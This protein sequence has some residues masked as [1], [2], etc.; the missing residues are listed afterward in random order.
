MDDPSR[1]APGTTWRRRAPLAVALRTAMPPGAVG[2]LAVSPHRAP[3]ATTPQNAVPLGATSHRAG[4]CDSEHRA[5][6]RCRMPRAAI[7]HRI[8]RR[9]RPPTV[10]GHRATG[11]PWP[12]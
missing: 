8:A 3:P 11:H 12:T 6:G 10:K 7:N 2:R 5:S 4:S 9:Q 1:R